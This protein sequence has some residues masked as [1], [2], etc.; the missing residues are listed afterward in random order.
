MTCELK[1]EDDEYHI[2][3]EPFAEGVVNTQSKECFVTN[4]ETSK[5][6]PDGGIGGNQ[7]G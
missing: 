2:S 3:V 6:M 5:I 4:Q 1:C 7:F